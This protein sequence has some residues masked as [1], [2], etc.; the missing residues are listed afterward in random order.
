VESAISFN[1]ERENQKQV[2]VKSKT[3][4]PP[5]S[6]LTLNLKAVEIPTII[7]LDTSSESRKLNQCHVVKMNLVIKSLLHKT[8][9][10]SLLFFNE[11]DGVTGPRQK[12]LI[13]PLKA[14]H[15]AWSLDE[16]QEFSSGTDNHL[17]YRKLSWVLGFSH[18]SQD[19]RV[20]AHDK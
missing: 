17:I 10:T 4:T 2:F 14:G 12:L 19:I 18:L 3:K 9:E 11:I 20:S 7:S 15:S 5:P 13:A 1:I 8:P 16:C 6:V